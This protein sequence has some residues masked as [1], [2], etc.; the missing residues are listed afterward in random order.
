MNNW[1]TVSHGRLERVTLQ[2]DGT[3][4]DAG[5]L[6][7]DLYYEA[8]VH[9]LTLNLHPD[10]TTAVS[11][12]NFTAPSGWTLSAD[13]RSISREYRTGQ[14]TV[15]LPADLMGTG[16]HHNNAAADPYR[17]G[18]ELLGWSTENAD[19]TH[20]FVYT[21][22]SE[23][24]NINVSMYGSAAFGLEAKTIADNYKNNTSWLIPGGSTAYLDASVANP[25]ANGIYSGLLANPYYTPD[26]VSLLMPATDLQ[27]WAVWAPD[28]NTEYTVYRYKI[29][30]NGN[31]VL[32]GS[33]TLTGITD[34]LTT[35]D[36]NYLENILGLTAVNTGDHTYLGRDLP[37][38]GYTYEREIK[39]SVTLPDG[40]V[41]AIRLW[42]RGHPRGSPGG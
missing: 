4:V 23:G 8:N 28:E 10:T 11:T 32:A 40:T 1:K 15:A 16:N 37:I 6:V 27:L 33:D 34:Q 30:G 20:F 25:Q 24:L 18:Y 39:A 19:T 42:H 22:P 2:P 38:A 41:V 31:K 13:G 35:V 12:G 9:T 29:D 21:N 17:A 3:F 26:G 7:L 14:T 5:A 36:R